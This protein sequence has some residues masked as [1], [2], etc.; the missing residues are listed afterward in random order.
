MT[1]ED[2][3]ELPCACATVRRTSRA[4]TQLYDS[5]LRA[6]GIEGPQ[7]A[8]LA[9]LDRRGP[10]SQAALGRHF[11]L[12]KTT[13]SRNLQVLQRT[14]WIRVVAGDDARERRVT[15][16]PAGRRRFERAR[17]AWRKAQEQL[18]SALG[19]AGWESLSTVLDAVTRA[20][21]IAAR[22]DTK[23]RNQ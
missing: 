11:D 7:F 17:P 8:L 3:P 23:A 6:H 12:D 19:D 21:Q 18:R 4:V 10:C 1:V 2:V 15:L 14:G 20:A 22:G 13:L 5:W 9:M 16:T